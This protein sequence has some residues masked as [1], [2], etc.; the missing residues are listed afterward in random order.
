MSTDD[1][2]ISS[3][4]HR[5]DTPGPSTSLDDAI[6]AASRDAVRKPAAKGPFS[7][8]WPAAASIA[9][10]IVI[11]IILVP[12]LKQ[13]ELQP[14]LT[15]TAREKT[16][17]RELADETGLNAYSTSEI[18]K[19][20]VATPSPASEPAMLREQSHLSDDQ[21]MPVASGVSSRAAKVPATSVASPAEKEE[22]QLDSDS[23]EMGRSRMQAA[24]SA[25][26]AILTPEM[27]EVKISRLIA[28]GKID[29]A[30]AEIGKL[31]KRYPEHKMDPSLLEKLN[32]HYE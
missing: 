19:K 24:D 21:A 30:I 5:G 2:K 14:E 23:V 18:K 27:W 6:L 26:F 9:A 7:G 20:S 29:E 8:A 1:D 28:Q 22:M 15:Q 4:Y 10:V 32:S 16:S 13:Q 31:E 25:P 12:V 17:T 3:L 11:T